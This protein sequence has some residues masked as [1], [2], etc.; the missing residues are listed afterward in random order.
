MSQTKLSLSGNDPARESLFNDIPAGDGKIANLFLVYA[1]RPT[2]VSEAEQEMSRSGK[3][4]RVC[5]TRLLENCATSN[6]EG[7][8]FHTGVSRILKILDYVISLIVHLLSQ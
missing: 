4:D 1:S 5:W 3:C 6:Q 2:E 8:S 7:R